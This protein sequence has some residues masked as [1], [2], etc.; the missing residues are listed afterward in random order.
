MSPRMCRCSALGAATMILAHRR[1]LAATSQMP[2]RRLTE[3]PWRR[4]SLGPHAALDHGPAD[5]RESLVALSNEQAAPET[6][7]ARRV[8][9]SR[10]DGGLGLAVE[11]IGSPVSAVR[12]DD[13][14]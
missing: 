8:V 2:K 7:A 11:L 1:G 5:R 12:P 9:V 6:G 4:P 10:R 13:G 14:A 3:K